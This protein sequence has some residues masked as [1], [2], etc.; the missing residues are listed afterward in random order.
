MRHNISGVRTEWM[1]STP[2]SHPTYVNDCN[3][4]AVDKARNERSRTPCRST[5]APPQGAALFLYYQEMRAAEHM[6]T[7]SSVAYALDILCCF[8]P[9]KRSGL[10]LINGPTGITRRINACSCDAN[11]VDAL[12][13]LD[14]AVSLSNNAAESDNVSKTA[15][16]FY[17]WNF[18]FDSSFPTYGSRMFTQPD[19]RR[20]HLAVARTIISDHLA[21]SDLRC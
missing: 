13:K 12:S 16:A 20:S 21:S 10:A 1:E 15:D 14:T 5:G 8:N 2:E 19:W 11:P 4:L 18:L 9:V 17:C 3:N 7:R 6:A